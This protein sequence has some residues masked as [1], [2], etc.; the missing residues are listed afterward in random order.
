M[1]KRG[2]LSRDEME[3]IRA[4]AHIK[5][6]ADIGEALNR[7]EDVVVKYIKDHVP[8]PKVLDPGRRRGGPARS[9]CAR[10]SGSPRRGRTSRRSS[11]TSELKFF[12]ECYL[13]MMAQLGRRPRDRGDPGLPRGQVRGPDEPEPE[14]AQDALEDIERLEDMQKTS[15]SRSSTA[16]SRR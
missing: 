16:T 9:P 8:P 1:P 2:R 3:Y 14:E 5:N 15:W 4:H 12:E 11:S 13:K 6:P 7:S 10:S